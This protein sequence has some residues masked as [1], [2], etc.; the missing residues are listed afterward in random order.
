[1]YR[2]IR[3]SGD[4]ELIILHDSD[5]KKAGRK[6]AY[7][8]CDLI[9]APVPEE[10]R[11]LIFERKYEKVFERRTRDQIEHYFD[12]NDS[13]S[14]GDVPKQDFLSLEDVWRWREDTIERLFCI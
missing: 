5:A 14:F 2:V 7:L 8:V 6:D 11:R 3:A 12:E 4:Y 1:M 13:I 10:Q 9:L